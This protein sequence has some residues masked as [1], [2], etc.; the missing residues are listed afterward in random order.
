MTKRNLQ[1][2]STT[3]CLREK[4]ATKKKVQQDHEDEELTSVEDHEEH[5]FDSN[6]V[7]QTMLTVALVRSVVEKNTTT[8]S[9]ATDHEES[10]DEG[11]SKAGTRYALR[12][13]RQRTGQDAERLENGAQF[14]K[15]G[16]ALDVTGSSS[17]APIPLNKQ[18]S[19][20]NP[21]EDLPEEDKS[22][23]MGLKVTVKREEEADRADQRG[24]PQQ[25]LNPS[26]VSNVTANPLRVT[27]S[28]SNPIS[29][30]NKNERVDTSGLNLVDTGLD[31]SQQSQEKE[32]DEVGSRPRG[33]SIDLD[34]KSSRTQ[35]GIV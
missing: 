9:T 5:A 16:Y 6:T 29:E 30:S 8:T 28:T 10:S 24:R 12:R 31:H 23:T 21:L 15:E 35:E 4:I 14:N 22:S 34:C 20:P 2:G 27:S 25:P 33:Y 7:E 32:D 18:Y 17:T 19:V 13:K 3:T 11:N 1:D 26:S